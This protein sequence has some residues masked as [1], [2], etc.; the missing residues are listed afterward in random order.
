MLNRILSIFAAVLACLMVPATALASGAEGD[1]GHGGAFPILF[2][3]IVIMLVLARVG[4]MMERVKQPAVLG[5]L[6]MGLLLA[7]A[8]TIPVLSA[9]GHMRTD[10]LIAGIAEIGVILLLFRT[11]LESNVKK[12]MSVGWSAF[13]VACIGV[14]L[15]FIAG[16]FF[17]KF[18]VPDASLAALLFM[19]A[20][21]TPT[22]VGITA[23][24]LRDLGIQKTKEANVILGA[25]VFDDIIG[26][27]ILAVV[28]GIATTG[29]ASVA[30]VGALTGKAVAFLGL[31][32]VVGAMAA[33]RL[34]KLFSKIHP[35]VGMK[36]ALALLFCATFSYGAAEFAGLAP[37]VGAFAA[38]LILDPVHFSAF[39]SPAMALKLRGWADRLKGNDGALAKEVVEAAEEEEHQHVENIIDNVSAFFVP[40][41]FVYTGFQVDVATFLDPSVLVT[42]GGMT[43]IAVL[44]KMVAGLGAGKDADRMLVG[45]GMVP[46]GEVGLIFADAGRRMGVLD[47]RM[48]S[49]I[50]VMVML[51][52]LVTP[53]LLALYQ[54]RRQARTA[55]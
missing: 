19:G 7:T 12:M 48:F 27:L 52:T 33:P 23:R 37:I 6:I 21:L 53:P 35:G 29:S 13:I 20:A 5:E 16:Y 10:P 2:L 18:L 8:I 3:F 15:P 43:V 46:R 47:D 1:V 36:M 28:A 51:T 31:S 22:S 30:E 40:I 39:A 42:A 41:F 17:M 26:L 34:G 24:V 54:R 55:V 9:L 25:A 44:C 50:V 49:I 4:A 45:I 32:V 14:A 38:G 11:G